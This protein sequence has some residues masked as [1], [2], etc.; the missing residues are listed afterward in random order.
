MKF[1]DSEESGMYLKKLL[2]GKCHG[3]V[4]PKDAGYA[5]FTIFFHRSKDGILIANR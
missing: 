2:P 3:P 5:D 4:L 1:P